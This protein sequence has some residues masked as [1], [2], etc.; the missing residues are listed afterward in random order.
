M[1]AALLAEL[2]QWRKNE[3]VRI[4]FV[5]KIV[6]I[7]FIALWLAYRL[8]LDS[9]ATSITTVF[10]VALPGSG[11]VLEKAFFRVIGTLVGCTAAVT[12][13]GLLPQAAPLLF[14]CLAIWVGLCTAGAAVFRNSKSYGFLLAG[15][16]ACM[17][18]IP[19]VDAPTQI[20]TLAITRVTE[21]GLGLICSAVISDALFP[22]HQGDQVL[23]AVQ[24]RYERFLALCR[25]TLE[26]R[27]TPAQVELTHLSFAAD[28]AALETTRSAAYFEAGRSYGESRNVHLFNAA[29]M[30]ALTT[31]YTL[32]RL[33]HRMRGNCSAQVNA[34][35]DALCHAFLLELDAIADSD[36]ETAC[37]QIRQRAARMRAEALAAGSESEQ[38]RIGLDT[39]I[40]LLER[41]ARNMHHF[42]Q[43]YLALRQK[44]PL[45]DRI[46]NVFRAFD[47]YAPRTPFPI[48]LASGLRTATATLVLAAIWYFLAWPYAAVAMLM[49]VVF[50]AL[51]ASSP[52]PPRMVRQI[53]LG[54]L[55]GVP[56]AFICNFF[57]LTHADGFAMLALCI[58]PF[59]AIGTYLTTM[60]KYAGIGLGLNLFLS[61]TIFPE[62]GVHADATA[63]MNNAI[64]FVLG[65]GLS[66]L[67][68]TVVLPRHTVGQRE[69]IASALWREARRTCTSV[70]PLSPHTFDNRIRDM[71]N[72]LNTGAGPAPDAATRAVV[73]Q[74]LTLLEL[75]HAVINMREL[76]PLSPS[77]AMRAALQRCITR[78][79]A[80]LRTPSHANRAAVVDAI[81]ASGRLVR[82]ER[83]AASA[84]RLPRLNMAYADLH[85]LYTLMLDHEQL[86]SA[87][88]EN[89]AA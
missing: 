18:A 70:R 20:F 2:T 73:G 72:Q 39:V 66:W 50:T 34:L 61:Q 67:V 35:T 37:M 42:Q 5:L 16:T 27:L 23:L 68:F 15:Y 77:A 56:S 87:E 17:I 81:L 19:A 13:V 85:S 22:R 84:A 11:M 51:A 55:L 6:S 29:F 79:A 31:F 49:T 9:P 47:S 88:G 41:F 33:L 25:D 52:N 63:Y 89:R 44:K 4:A 82:E 64:A 75:G 58:A 7:A 74:A 32:H 59:I 14:L 26:N 21:V 24:G 86:M 30:T 3:G 83:V 78:I 65:A 71:M 62:N 1:G 40:E 76:I 60:P 10:I 53:G 80:F 48:V 28:V 38:E 45:P 46:G 12:L 36:V 8:E 57:L 43:V 69:Y 54:F